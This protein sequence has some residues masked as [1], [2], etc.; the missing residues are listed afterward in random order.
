MKTKQWAIWGAV[1]LFACS[2]LCRHN[3]IRTG[4]LNNWLLAAAFRTIRDQYQIIKLHAQTIYRPGKG[5]GKCID[6]LTRVCFKGATDRLTVCQDKK[7]LL[8]ALL[9]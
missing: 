1:L 9:T 5:A 3:E 4:K 6:R 2:T 8:L 7:R